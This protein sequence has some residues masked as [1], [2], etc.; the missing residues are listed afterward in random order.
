[1]PET[2]ERELSMTK[3]KT[4]SKPGNY[5][6]PKSSTFK[7]GARGGIRSS[8]KMEAVDA[9]DFDDLTQSQLVDVLSAYSDAANLHG[10]DRQMLTSTMVGNSREDFAKN[11]H[12]M[13]QSSPDDVKK[14]MSEKGMH[15]SDEPDSSPMDNAVKGLGDQLGNY[16]KAGDVQSGQRLMDIANAGGADVQGAVREATS[17]T[18]AALFVGAEA[19]GNVNIQKSIVEFLEGSSPEQRQ[20]FEDKVKKLLGTGGTP[21]DN[22]KQEKAKETP[23]YQRVLDL[24]RERLLEQDRD[25]GRALLEEERRLTGELE[26]SEEEKA[27]KNSDIHAMW[28]EEY[29]NADDT[30][31]EFVQ[32]RI[33]KML[34]KLSP[35]EVERY[36]QK[37]EEALL[38]R[39]GGEDNVADVNEGV[40]EQ[41]AGVDEAPRA[42]GADA[43][44]ES[45]EVGQDTAKQEPTAGDKLSNFAKM[46]RENAMPAE[47]KFE[48]KSIPEA[49]KRL[50]DIIDKH[51]GLTATVTVESPKKLEGMS[52]DDFVRLERDT[53]N[54]IDALAQQL[55]ALPPEY[56]AVLDKIIIKPEKKWRGLT[57]EEMAARREGFLQE[58]KNSGYKPEVLSARIA[59]REIE[60]YKADVMRAVKEEFAA[61][62]ERELLQEGGHSDL[63]AARAEKLEGLEQEMNDA[64]NKQM[65]AK[66]NEILNSKMTN[67]EVEQTIAAAMDRAD[68]SEAEIFDVVGRVNAR[69]KSVYAGTAEFVIEPGLAAEGGFEQWDHI[70]SHEIGHLKNIAWADSLLSC[71]AA[72]T[73]GIHVYKPGKVLE[74]LDVTDDKLQ[75]NGLETAQAP[76]FAAFVDDWTKVSLYTTGKATI[77]GKEVAV[78]QAKGNMDKAKAQRLMHIAFG[79]KYAGGLYS[80]AEMP[81]GKGVREE[82]AEAHRIYS[83][84]K[85]DEYLSALRA[86]GNGEA[87]DYLSGLFGVIAKYEKQVGEGHMA[88]GYKK[89]VQK[90][91]RAAKSKK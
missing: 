50:R 75:M 57:P 84:P 74:T 65:H 44:V 30:G 87:A 27:R 79:S 80:D 13:V 12:K 63:D 78:W 41:S 9:K 35:E 72:V 3:R 6:S 10:T 43:S 64:Y 49:E 17:A 4:L 42:E 54:A 91:K 62:V 19:E 39:Q 31:N 69:S 66:Y 18:L 58:K 81:T 36:N 45:N 34:S 52:P 90:K 53:I 70:L 1:M 67:D 48:S 47:R 77:D 68:G 76:E 26:L 59:N 8:S 25:K 55:E 14:R 29:I 40:E 51:P 85:R 89:L 24:K 20:S 23:K 82:L 7:R 88:P 22:R 21:G 56:S 86:S 32:N 16:I 73:S 38:A 61:R 5:D 11:L 33:D 71:L 37:Y 60:F 2:K 28:A 15:L 46:M 83:H